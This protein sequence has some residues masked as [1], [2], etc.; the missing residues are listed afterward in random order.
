MSEV[1]QEMIYKA[2]DECHWRMKVHDVDICTG[3]VIPCSF[4]IEKG[5]CD[6]LKK[7]FTGA[8]N[9]E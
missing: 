6:T 4:N 3:D 5:A 8:C 1:T 7:L 2:V 9:D